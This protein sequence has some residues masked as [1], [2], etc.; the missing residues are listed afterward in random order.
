MSAVSARRLVNDV[1]SEICNRGTTGSV[2]FCLFTSRILGQTMNETSQ[3]GTRR[4]RLGAREA[5]NGLFD[6]LKRRISNKV[7]SLALAFAGIS[8]G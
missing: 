5:I 6:M 7:Q 4:L 8:F 3:S 2:F 1:Q